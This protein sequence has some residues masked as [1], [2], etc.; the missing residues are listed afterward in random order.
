MKKIQP[1][2]I[3]V[4][5]MGEY[6]KTPNGPMKAKEFLES[7]RLSVH[8]FVHPNGNY[9]KIIETPNKAS[10]AGKSEWNG[11]KYLN[12]HY[13]GFELLLEGEHDYGSFIKGI[14]EPDAYTQEQFDKAVAICKYWMDLYEIPLGNVVRHS[15]VSGDNVRGKGKGKK[16]PGDG[17]DWEAFKKALS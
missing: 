12:S 14:N 5:S 2:G 7:L 16:D 13:I 17:F 15:D 1:K 10:H 6:I 4:H 9:E 8:G 3:I 11:L